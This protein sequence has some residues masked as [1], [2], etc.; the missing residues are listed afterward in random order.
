[1]L[2]YF[3]GLALVWFL[4]CRFGLRC[5]VSLIWWVCVDGVVFVGFVG[6]VVFTFLWFLG[7]GVISCFLVD[8]LRQVVFLFVGLIC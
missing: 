4:G 6:A 1:M 5:L 3:G 8:F 2:G 7:L